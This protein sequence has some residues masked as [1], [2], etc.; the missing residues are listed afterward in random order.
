[1][2]VL[3][4]HIREDLNEVFYIGIG[5]NESRAYTEYKRSFAWKNITK[6]VKYRV[7]IILRDLTWEEACEREKEYIKLYGRR[8]LGLGSLVNMTDG[9]EGGL[10]KI[11]SEKHR[12]SISE[13]Q[14]GRERTQ[15]SINKFKKKM[16]GRE[17]SEE[18]KDSISN[19]LLG[20]KR[21]EEFKKKVK[22]ARQINNGMKNKKHT[23]EVK[24]RMSKSHKLR[25]EMN[26]KYSGLFINNLI[27][28]LKSGATP[29]ELMKKYNIP[30]TSYYRLIK[31]TNE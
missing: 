10:G 24:S 11:I 2:A 14:K 21:T 28:E 30:K 17:L 23:D 3:Y 26:P 13:A 29:T 31:N 15:E 20:I 22:L 25:Y 4:K 27:K 9:G 7:E 18:H 16:I 5:E 6:K 1:M 12:R 8:D 19:S